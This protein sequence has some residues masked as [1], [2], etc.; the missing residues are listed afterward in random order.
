M[1][2]SGETQLP[3]E[4]I[5]EVTDNATAPTTATAT[6]TRAS[7]SE[8]GLE[9]KEKKKSALMSRIATALVVGGLGTF[10]VVSGGP[11][12]AVFISF[13]V[14]QCS[15]EYI[16]LMTSKNLPKGVKA[17][18]MLLRRTMCLLSVGMIAAA[19]KGIRTGVFE[20]ASFILLSMLLLKRSTK[21]KPSKKK[22]R[23]SE[24]TMLVF[25]L[26]Y[27]GYLPTFWI[28]LRGVSVVPLVD[29]PQLV[30][31][32]LS[33]MNVEWTVGLLATFI[34]GLSV[35][36]ADTGA[37]IGGKLMGSTPLISISPNKT[38][39]GAAWGFF[40]SL[41]VTLSFNYWFQF[42][43]NLVMAFGFAVAVYCASVFGDLIESSMKRAAGKKDS[44]ALLPGHGGLL[45][46]FD[47]YIFTGVLAYALVYWYY[48]FL[49]MPLGQLIIAPPR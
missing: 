24:L 23:F 17:P 38:I 37:F 14:F 39:E 7:E 3:P 48:Y 16:G 40:A 5:P 34:S 36:A 31:Q 25:G 32:L 45:D 26:F 4:E 20:F 49:G 6:A 30:A 42:P 35:V 11:L 1:D 9:E 43:G 15:L 18:P 8:A 46:R 29:P 13:I 22:V 19:H 2:T 44:G 27:C 41:A 28:R 33:W 47:S 10:F 12:Y 21:K